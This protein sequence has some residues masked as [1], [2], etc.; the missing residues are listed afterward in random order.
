M[1]EKHD[2]NDDDDDDDESR[3]Q[4]IR[5]GLNSSQD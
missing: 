3:P 2:D 5:S 1:Q 4:L